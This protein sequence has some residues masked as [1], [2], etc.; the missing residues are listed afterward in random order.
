MP[1]II[2][3]PTV[4][5]AFQKLS[6][7]CA[8]SEHAPADMELKMKAWGMA[9]REQASVMQ[10]LIEA[11]YINHSRYAHAFVHDKLLYVGWGR[12]KLSFALRQ[13]GIDAES[14]SEALEGIDEEDYR[15]VL[16]RLLISKKRQTR[17]SDNAELRLKLLRFSASRGFETDVANT[18]IRALLRDADNE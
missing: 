16:Q 18:L 1:K 4:E 14:I 5:E 12:Q 8:R 13:K 3:I 9:E 2:K 7:L 10:K 6:A 15:E 11:N 17:A